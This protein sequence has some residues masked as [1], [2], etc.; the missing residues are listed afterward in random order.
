MAAQVAVHLGLLAAATLAL[1]SYPALIE[2]FLKVYAEID[3]RDIAYGVLGLSMICVGVIELRV[4]DDAQDSPAAQS[5]D[6]TCPTRCGRLSC[7]ALAAA[8]SS[9]MPGVTT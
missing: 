4:H 6:S 5:H 1:I 2:P 3:G 7:L 8:P 9:L